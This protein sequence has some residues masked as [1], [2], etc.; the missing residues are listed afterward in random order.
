[1]KIRLS[2]EEFWAIVDRAKLQVGCVQFS[3]RRLLSYPQISV[4]G[5]QIRAHRLI[6]ERK[7]GREIRPGYMAC[8]KCDDTNCI[9]EAHIYEG[10]KQQNNLDAGAN[11]RGLAGR[12]HCPQGHE[13]IGDNVIFY[14]GGRYCRACRDISNKNWRQRDA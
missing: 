9:Q 1:M 4:G 3:R 12:T 13:Y 14:R 11:H 8:H 6:L 7:L 10:T 5:K 2:L